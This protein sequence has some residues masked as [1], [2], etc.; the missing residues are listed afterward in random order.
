[1]FSDESHKVAIKPL[2]VWLALTAPLLPAVAEP[3]S[4]AELT[5]LVDCPTAG[6]VQKGKYAFALRF[7]AAGGVSGQLD[8]GALQ[9]LT[10]SVAYGG[11][12]ILG[13]RA[14]DWYPR[15]EAGVRYRIVEESAAWPALVAGYE[16][17]GYGA[18]DGDRYEIKSKGLFLSLSKNYDSVLGQFGI[19]AG[20][21]LTRETSDGDDDL[22]GWFGADKTVNDDLALL[23]EADL[24]RNGDGRPGSGLD[25]VLVNAGA[26]LQ[27]APQ[28]ILSLFLK[29]LLTN[30]DAEHI[31]RE[32]S[33]RYTEEF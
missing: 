19:H 17:R 9:R 31:E 30:C 27:L 15:L 20:M 25:H 18:Y 1:M 4:Q 11:E 16:T 24:G 8:A 7:F 26:R 6:V 5:H 3:S 10:I 14:I 2:V 29:D 32:L 28:L 21:N 33:V 23:A 22:S 13:D 12:R